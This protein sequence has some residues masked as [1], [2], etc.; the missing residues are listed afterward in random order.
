MIW[1]FV[2]VKQK[3]PIINAAGSQVVTEHAESKTDEL[4]QFVKGKWDRVVPL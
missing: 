4:N 2:S 1:N 3:D